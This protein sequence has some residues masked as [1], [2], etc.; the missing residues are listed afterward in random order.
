[1]KRF[2]TILASAGLAAGCLSVTFTTT[3]KD[4]GAVV[5]KLG[6]LSGKCEGSATITQE[7]GTVTLTRTQEGDTCHLAADFSARAVDMGELRA[8]VEGE[9]ARRGHEAISADVVLKA[10]L[11]INV[12]DIKLDG[13]APP[14]TDWS[15]DVEVAEQSL[16][17]L[18]GQDLAALMTQDVTATLGDAQVKVL[19]DLYRDGGVVNATGQFVL[20]S[21]PVAWLEALPVGGDATLSF[22]VGATVTAEVTVDAGN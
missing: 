1:M 5:V 22:T 20:G 7:G 9:I 10:P 21:V 16:L 12:K 19:N 6:D 2:A 14:S 13:F 18:E 11:T 3:Q 15:V 8:K 4:E 17:A